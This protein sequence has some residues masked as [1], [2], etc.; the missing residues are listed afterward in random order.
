[1]MNNYKIKKHGPLYKIFELQTRQYV[2]Q[3]KN[4]N[5]INKL[6]KAMNDGTF[7]EG[8]TPKYMLNDGPI[9]LDNELKNNARPRYTRNKKRARKVL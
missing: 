8:N 5:N 2:V 9:D 3:S 7:F 6:C 4:R 1:M